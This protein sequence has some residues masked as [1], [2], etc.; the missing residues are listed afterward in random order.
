MKS[1]GAPSVQDPRMGERRAVASR[2]RVVA[3]LR[4]QTGAEGRL[5]APLLI[6]MR[7]EAIRERRDTC[8][9]ILPR[10]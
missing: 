7:S 8:I 6:A 3:L 2:D 4:A 9:E 5:Q 1:V 10:G